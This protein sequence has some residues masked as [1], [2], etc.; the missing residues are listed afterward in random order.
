MDVDALLNAKTLRRWD[1]LFTEKLFNIP[2][3][4]TGYFSCMHSFGI[5]P[6]EI[7]RT[8]DMYR[9]ESSVSALPHVRT[10]LLIV[11]ARDDPLFPPSVFPSAEFIRANSHLIFAST[12]YGGHVAWAEGGLSW[13][14]DVT[15]MDRVALD[16]IQAHIR[17][18]R[19][20]P[21]LPV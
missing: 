19:H 11:N 21:E 14:Q 3:G 7:P 4:T 20:A 12:R 2:I 8:D 16:W 5:C 9:K 17:T 13:P 10:S 6:N 15:Y 1:E 18:P